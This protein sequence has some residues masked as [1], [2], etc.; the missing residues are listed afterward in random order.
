M[1]WTSTESSLQTA[2]PCQWQPLRSPCTWNTAWAPS[3]L[4]GRARLPSRPLPGSPGLS[5]TGLWDCQTCLSASR[6]WAFLLLVL[7]AN[8]LC[9]QL[10]MTGIL[11]CVG[12]ISDVTS[13]MP[14]V[15]SVTSHCF[16][17]WRYSS[18][19]GVNS[20]LFSHF[21]PHWPWRVGAEEASSS[22]PCS[23]K[24]P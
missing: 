20:A 22:A 2:I 21:H 8:A 6:P 13:M 17:F 3:I 14:F 18:G 16:H 5:H 23:L 19:S 12:L 7:L 10:C 1:L 15:A 9:P 11:Y 4:L 24:W